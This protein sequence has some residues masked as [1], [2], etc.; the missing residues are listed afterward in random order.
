MIEILRGF[1]YPYFFSWELTLLVVIV[2]CI[3]G[4]AIGGAVARF[5]LRILTILTKKGEIRPETQISFLLIVFGLALTLVG[6]W[7]YFL[8]GMSMQNQQL[9]LDSTDSMIPAILFTMSAFFVGW[10]R[11]YKRIILSGA[12]RASLFPKMENTNP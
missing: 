12:W 6:V 11:K 7:L 1:A 9:L 4:V 10:E 2:G 8:P 3:F 5:Q